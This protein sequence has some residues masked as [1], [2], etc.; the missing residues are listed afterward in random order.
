MKVKTPTSPEVTTTSLAATAAGQL[1]AVQLGQENE[2]RVVVVT[3]LPR[4][5]APLI[6]NGEHV[7]QLGTSEITDPPTQYRAVVDLTSGH[8]LVLPAATEVLELE[9][10][11]PL[12]TS[13]VTKYVPSEVKP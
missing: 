5:V 7:A 3:A 8:L 10:A 12:R 9:Q 13:Y 1:V 6:I 4:A 2:P 11:E